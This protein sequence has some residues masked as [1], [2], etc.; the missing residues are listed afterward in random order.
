MSR[1]GC[2][3]AA[4]RRRPPPARRRPDRRSPP[5]R[6]PRSAGGGPER[7]P[8]AL[9]AVTPPARATAAKPQL[10]SA[11][12]RT[13][14]SCRAGSRRGTRGP[15]PSLRAAH[16][17]GPRRLLRLA[18]ELRTGGAEFGDRDGADDGNG[19]PR[20]ARLLR[21]GRGRRRCLNRRAFR[22][23]RTRLMPDAGPGSRRASTTVIPS[24]TA[25]TLAKATLCRRSVTPCSPALK[26]LRRFITRLVAGARRPALPRSSAKSEA[27][28]T[29]M[30]R[31]RCGHRCVVSVDS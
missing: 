3:I 11:P 6:A 21:L 29:G 7:P 18:L 10:G 25:A 31:I 16:G 2:C 12:R 13:G 9:A 4:A 22:S 24:K 17:A 8:P 1:A 20:T 15:R 23:L 30:A 19:V 28:R 26:R 27:E 5:P 14:R